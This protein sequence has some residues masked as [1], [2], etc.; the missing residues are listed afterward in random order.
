[1]N[2][3][4][5]ALD[6]TEDNTGASSGEPLLVDAEQRSSSVDPDATEMAEVQGELAKAQW[7]HALAAAEAR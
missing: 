1:M 5:A 2:V 3:V 4:I 7:L 6:G